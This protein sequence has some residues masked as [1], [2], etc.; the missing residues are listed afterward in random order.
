MTHLN[1]KI[2]DTDGKDHEA[3]VI[4]VDIKTI[5][6][7]KAVI[8]DYNIAYIDND[9]LPVTPINQ[10]ASS[11]GRKLMKANQSE[12]SIREQLATSNQSELSN[13]DSIAAVNQSEAM[14]KDHITPINQSASSISNHVTNPLMTSHETDIRLS[15]YIEI[16]ATP[17]LTPTPTLNGS[18]LSVEDLFCQSR[19]DQPLN[20]GLNLS[21]EDLFGNSLAASEYSVGK[22]IIQEGS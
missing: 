21:V 5:I 10:S 18:V 7:D 20:G 15:S 1:N 16:G 9:S 3:Q 14:L 6:N 2:L 11:N 13:Q 8:D 17:T 19:M 12:S 22:E 4:N